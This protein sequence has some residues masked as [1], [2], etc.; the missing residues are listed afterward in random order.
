[1]LRGENGLGGHGGA[2]HR[3]GEGAVGRVSWSLIRRRTWWTGEV[4][5]VLDDVGSPSF[6][7][8]GDV[9]DVFVDQ[10]MTCIREPQAQH[11]PLQSNLR[12]Q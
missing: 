8:R 2:G 9:Y 10:E 5:V 1:M 12:E 11:P 6:Q 4:E 3:G 7:S